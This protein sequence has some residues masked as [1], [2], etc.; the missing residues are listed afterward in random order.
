MDEQNMFFRDLETT[1]LKIHS[2]AFTDHSPV[3]WPI[4]LRADTKNI[5]PCHN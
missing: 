3:H 1:S 5:F 4:L 2:F